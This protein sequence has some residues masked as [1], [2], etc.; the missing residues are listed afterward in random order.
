MKTLIKNPRVRRAWSL[1]LVGLGGLLLL[2]AP[3]GMLLGWIPLLLGVALEL[4]AIALG[5]GR[6]R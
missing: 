5:V 2:L 4:V 6:D 3:E 1:S